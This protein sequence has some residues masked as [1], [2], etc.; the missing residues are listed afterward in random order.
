VVT[1]LPYGHVPHN[2]TLPVGV[3]ATLDAKRGDLVIDAP[4]VR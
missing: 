2:A 4:A 1:G 3:T